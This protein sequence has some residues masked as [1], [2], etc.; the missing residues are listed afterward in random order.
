[1][2]KR[3]AGLRQKVGEAPSLRTEITVAMRAG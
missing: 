2:P 3:L 1:L